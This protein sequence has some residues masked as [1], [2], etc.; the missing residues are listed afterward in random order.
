MGCKRDLDAIDAL[1]L[2]YEKVAVALDCVIDNSRCPPRVETL[3]FIANDY[4][5]ELGKALQIIEN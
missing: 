2:I 4:L 1:G 3:A 5:Q